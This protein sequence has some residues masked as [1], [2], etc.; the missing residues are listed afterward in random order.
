M[1]VVHHLN[2]SR[3]QRILWLLEELNRPYRVETISAGC[4]NQ[5]SAVGTA[6][7]SSTR[8]VTGHSR[9]RFGARQIRRH[10]RVSA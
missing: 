9:R 6:R 4:E 10:H 1:I 2:N 5:S 7:R 3:S 8:Q